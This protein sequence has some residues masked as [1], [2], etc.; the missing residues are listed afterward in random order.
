MATPFIKDT[1]P[2]AAEAMLAK[3][4]EA[5]DCINVV[6]SSPELRAQDYEKL[7]SARWK[8]ELMKFRMVEHMP[9]APA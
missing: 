7:H 3:I 8:M 9:K 2:A 5:L 1:T 4:S 6:M